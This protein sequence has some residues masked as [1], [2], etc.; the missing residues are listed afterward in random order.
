[1]KEYKQTEKQK[2]I[3]EGLNKVYE[4]LIEFKKKMNSE[5]V[6]LKDNRIVKVKP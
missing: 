5:L 4:R 3:L 6:I 2:K 1:M